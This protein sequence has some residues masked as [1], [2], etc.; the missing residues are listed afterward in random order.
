MYSS[1]TVTREKSKSA[2]FS[3]AV[4][5]SKKQNKILNIFFYAV[6]GGTFLSMLGIILY[7]VYAY[8]SLHSGAH[9]FDWLLGIFSDFVEIMNIS[10]EESPYLVEDSSYPP[11]AIA[12]LYPFALICKG[13]LAKYANTD[14]SVDE[15]TSQVILHPQFWVAMVLFFVVCSAVIIFAVILAY[16]LPPVQ[17]IKVGIII[18]TSAPFVYAVM[19]GN[20]IYFALI[21]L[22][23]FL[24]LYKNENAFVREIGYICLVLAGLIK[25]YP[26]F[27]GV[28]LLCEKR[29][30]ASVRIALYTVGFFFLS[31]FLL[32]GGINNFEPFV[33]NLGGFASNTVRLGAGNNLSATS[34]VYK[35]LGVFSDN[36]SY[37][38][39]LNIVS[40]AVVALVFLFSTALA[41]YTRCEFSRFVIASATVILL[42]SVSY[43]Y[44]LIFMLLPFMEFI[45]NYDELDAKTKRL[46]TV[47]FF[48]V[49][50][51]PI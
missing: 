17:S 8:A 16:K 42:P 36:P 50:L 33:Q 6:L 25:I 43:F 14:M 21:F 9:S 10:L 31:F 35:L 3:G 1:D 40:L 19:R 44:V 49:F 38:E 26:L 28:F 39:T 22:L 5:F 46:Y 41:I 37:S 30:W 13:V 32:D 34:L 4:P 47:L 45:R 20:T 2:L 48:I 24:L 51:T 12:V 15:L 23:L 29:I 27:F 18:L 11:L 7:Y